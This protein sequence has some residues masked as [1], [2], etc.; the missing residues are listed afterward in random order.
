MTERSVQIKVYG[1]VQGV[2]YRTSTRTEAEALGISG[3]VRNEHD[4][5]VYIEA[6]GSLEQIGKLIDWCKKGPPRS[7]VERV[8]VT[9]CIRKE[10]NTFEIKRL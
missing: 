3:I 1:M 4:G 9:E 10:F 6:T 7:K 5:S 2:N 8:E